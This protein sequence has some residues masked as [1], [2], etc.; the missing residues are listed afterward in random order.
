MF[1]DSVVEI[2]FTKNV[3]NDFLEY[4]TLNFPMRTIGVIG[5]GF[6]YTRELE[7]KGNGV[8]FIDKSIPDE[9]AVI[10]T[11]DNAININKAKI[12]N[13]PYVVLTDG[14]PTSAFSKY[15]VNGNRIDKYEY[16]KQVF[17]DMLSNPHKLQAESGCL[18]LE[19]LVEC[20]GIVG[21]TLITARAKRARDRAFDLKNLLTAYD[22]PEQVVAT[23]ATAIEYIDGLTFRLFIDYVMSKERVGNL[24]RTRFYSAFS[25]L[26]LIR[27][28]TNIDF[29]VILPY[30]DSLRARMLAQ[31]LG[32]PL[33]QG[34]AKSFDN[35]DY[36]LSMVEELLPTEKELLELKKRFDFLTPSAPVELNALINDYSL[37][38]ECVDE[39]N[40]YT[41][42]VKAGYF[43]ALIE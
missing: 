13:K 18:A 15:A 29:C 14:V 20:I 42:L 38:T 32:I 10:V 7:R 39:D 1:Y 23:C 16:P 36:L 26:F 3:K 27:R 30:M 41:N 24:A 21:S 25:V 28:F 40:L 34:K 12:S 43:D 33:P 2:K 9:V 8:V 22:T 11:N 17:I 37:A 4:I 35:A 19:V 6:S 5:E 31:S